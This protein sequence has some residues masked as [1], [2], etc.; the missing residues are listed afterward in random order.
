MKADP[1]PAAQ[2][3]TVP[4]AP[5]PKSKDSLARLASR[6]TIAQSA[7]IREAAS[8]SPVDVVVKDIS[9]GGARISTHL[10][11]RP[12]QRVTL[13]LQISAATRIELP[14]RVIHSGDI[15]KEYRCMYGLRFDWLTEDVA[16]SLS[17]FVYERL[18]LRGASL[19]RAGKGK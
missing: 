18:S 12:N 2:A 1:R 10:R 5:A 15:G 3:H 8:Q 9:V 14:A 11:L 16:R 7:T 19:Q 13:T 17:E 6:V 4:P